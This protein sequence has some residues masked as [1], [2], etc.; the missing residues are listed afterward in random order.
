[1]VNARSFSRTAFRLVAVGLLTS[2]CGVLL[3]VASADAVT[4]LPQTITYLIPPPVIA[5]VGDSYAAAVVGGGS[6]NPVTFSSTGSCSGDSIGFLLFD[7]V[8]TCVFTADQAGD[9]NYSAAPSVTVSITVVKASQAITFTSTP[10]ANPVVGGTFQVTATGGRSRQPVTFAIDPTSSAGACTVN[11][12][13][14]VRFTSVGTCIIDA[15][16]AGDHNYTAAPQVTQ[17]ITVGKTSQAITFTSSRPASAVVGDTYQVSATGGGS[18]NAVTF[19]IDPTSTGCGVSAT[20]LAT[21]TG[22]GTCQIDADQAGN[23]S[24]A[25]APRVSQSVVVGKAAQVLTLTSTPPAHPLVGGTYRI[26]AS[27]GGSGNPVT[28][29]VDAASTGGACTVDATGLVTFTGPGTCVIAV[30]QAGDANYVAAHTSLSL[31]SS[32]VPRPTPGPGPGPGPTSVLPDVSAAGDSGG[33]PVTGTN[34]RPVLGLAGALL[35][36]GLVLLVVT[37]QRRDEGRRR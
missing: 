10:P 14:L 1:M 34:A 11:G 20:G 24:Y 27:G 6:M 31:A 30:D 13:G 25:D 26:D 5:Q 8:G 7:S 28:F 15:N 18:G 9:A 36:A 37:G 29:S 2:S 21:F 19:S 12:S 3:G 4:K 33:L 22:A 32:A 35:L 16:Q 17:S 23:S